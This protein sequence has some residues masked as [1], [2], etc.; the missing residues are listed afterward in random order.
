MGLLQYWKWFVGLFFAD[1]IILGITN[2]YSFQKGKEAVYKE[3]AA[4]PVK[5]K[6]E[7]KHDT[8]PAPPPVI[9]WLKP[10]KVYEIPPEVLSQINSMGNDI[11]RYKALLAEKAKPWET[12]IDSARFSLSILT[13]PW[14]RTNEINLQ[15]KPVPYSYPEITNSKVI[16]KDPPWWHDALKITGGIAAGYL[17][18]KNLK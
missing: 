3:I 13:R 15:L 17:I 11:E 14:T 4:I 16:V 2:F 18:G 9:K 10:D 12:K 6:I 7:W 5:T 8:L 1:L